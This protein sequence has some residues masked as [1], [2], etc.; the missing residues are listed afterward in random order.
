MVMGCTGD[1]V[2][3]LCPERV[4]TRIFQHVAPSVE[5]RRIRAWNVN[6]SLYAAWHR[7]AYSSIDV[8]SQETTPG[9]HQAATIR[10]PLD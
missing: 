2:K 8:L 1:W 6:L 5:A 4:Y 10:H 3:F 9:K 7:K